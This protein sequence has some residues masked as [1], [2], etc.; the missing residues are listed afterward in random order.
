MILM[1]SQR[2]LC[3]CFISFLFDSPIASRLNI[4]IISQATHLH[5]ETWLSPLSFLFEGLCE[6]SHTNV[7][8]RRGAEGCGEF[9]KAH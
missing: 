8:H 3:I 2:E 1:F 5:T 4:R 9:G 6:E 7:S